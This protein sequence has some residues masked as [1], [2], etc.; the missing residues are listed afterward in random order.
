MVPD[1]S[2]GAIVFLTTAFG[3]SDLLAQRIDASGNLVWAANGITVCDT[4]NEQQT[5]AAIPDGSGGAIVTWTDYP[6]GDP[7]RANVHAQHLTAEGALLW[8]SA[9]LP[10]CTAAGQQAHTRC[11]SDGAGGAITA[12]EDSRSG[13]KAAYAQRIDRNG[14]WGYP[15][16]S[17]AAV[18]DVPGDQ[19]GFANLSWLASR[20]DAWPG[21]AVSSY[22][23]WRAI[24]P[25]QAA[26]TLKSGGATL[27]DVADFGS[28]PA[29]PLVR[30]ER[31]AGRTFYWSFV[32]TVP[33]ANLDGYAEAVPTLFDST[34]VCGERHYFQVIA[35]GSDPGTYWISAPD[36]GRSVDNLAPAPP[37]GLAGALTE[38]AAG[39]RLIWNRCRETDLD[40]YA[41]YRGPAESF[42]PAPGNRIAAL[43]DTTCMDGEWRA[44]D[45]Y[46]YKVASVD[47]H[48]NG[49]ACSLLRPEDVAGE[50]AQD[51]PAAT[52]LAQNFPNP[53]NPSTKIV[54]G[55]KQPEL[56]SL[57]IYDAAGRLVRVLVDL[58]LAAGVHE[59]LWN[60]RDDRGAPVSSGVYFCRLRAGSF[61]SL[62]KMV[63]L[64]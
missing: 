14:N 26:Q 35:H 39:L 54:F 3:R 23:V 50:E 11:V 56:V 41:V 61:E 18:R 20:L 60:G 8:P 21:H 36:S 57:R 22:S 28:G 10:V 1:G 37:A 62:R 15:A 48:G 9:G 16:P 2:G 55:L 59:A 34:A 64:K 17:I 12:W 42:E 43:A 24:S 38:S 27:S 52:F 44:G 63:L 58:E 4:P 33:A 19:G 29:K 53:F 30:I 5:P 6:T 32:S 25:E 49:S 40:H 51:M 7:L 31:A 46:Y 13:T 45:R 47:I